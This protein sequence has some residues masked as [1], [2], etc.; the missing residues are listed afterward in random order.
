MIE[1]FLP[2]VMD[3]LKK[4]MK[5]DIVA[6][7]LFVDGTAYLHTEYTVSVKVKGEVVTSSTFTAV[8]NNPVRK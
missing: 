2:Q 3:F 8:R 6:N 5:L 4:N 7:D 1:L